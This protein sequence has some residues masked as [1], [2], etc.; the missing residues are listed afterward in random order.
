MSTRVIIQCQIWNGFNIEKFIHTLLRHVPSEH[1]TGLDMI[2]V[3][4]QVTHKP[5]RKAGGIYWQKRGRRQAAIEIAVNAIYKGMPR[6]VLFLPFIAKFMLANVVYHEIGHHYQHFT[7]GVTR[8]EREIFAEQYRKQMLRKAFLRWRLFLFPL[9]PLIRW[10][11]RI[12]N[13]KSP[14]GTTAQRKTQK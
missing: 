11:S 7:H 6:F 3:V 12:V 8:R 2:V 5:S 9:A 4:D 10:L 14:L 1:L 13:S